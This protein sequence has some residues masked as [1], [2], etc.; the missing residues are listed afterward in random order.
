MYKRQVVSN[1]QAGYIELVFEKTGLGKYFTG[2]LCPGDS[3][4]AKAA[5]IRSIAKMCIRDSSFILYLQEQE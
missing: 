5:N 2:H 3:G 4:E 1:C